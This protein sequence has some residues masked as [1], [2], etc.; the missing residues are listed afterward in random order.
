MQDRIRLAAVEFDAT[1]ASTEENLEKLAEWCGRAR[2]QGVELALFPELSVTGFIPNHPEG[3]HSAWL[4]DALRGARRMAE[5]LDGCAVRRLSEIVT[6]TGMMI[7]AGMLEDAGNMLYNTHVLVGQ[8]GLLGAWRKL[9]IPIFEM[10]LYN[11]GPAP[12]VVETQLGK[13]G[14]NICFDA[15]LPESTRLLA[16]QN[17]EIVLFPFAADP[18]PPGPTGWEQW[19]EPVLRVRC[20]ENGVFGLASNYSGEVSFAGVQQRFYG[21]A[22]ALGP[23]GNVLA[24]GGGQSSEPRMLV[25]DFDRESLECARAGFEYTFRFRRPELYVSLARS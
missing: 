17:A 1:T 3:E 25:V 23:D 19:A 18:L 13:I 10:P 2:E 6:H 16:V 11:G 20:A 14:I 4:R 5:R 21:G 15:F 22:L 9:H 24:R 7:A 12:P 8:A